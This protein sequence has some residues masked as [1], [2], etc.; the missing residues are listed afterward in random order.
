VGAVISPLLANVYLHRLDQEMQRAGFR[1]VR[2]ADDFIVTANRRWKVRLADQLVRSVLD[3]VGLSLNEDKTGVRNLNRDEID[4]LG[5]SFYAGRFLRPRERA[6]AAFKDRIRHLTRRKRGLSLQAII[7]SL[8]P[9]IR[10]WGIYFVE[11]HVAKLFEDLDQWIRMR[12]R[13]YVLGR[14]SMRTHI[15]RWMTTAT[16]HDKLGL[17]SLVALR[18]NYLSPGSG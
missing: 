2:Y 9:V 12:V 1:F 14:P 10:G 4:F 8:N 11:G 13:S 16:L 18:R 3:D 7:T 5:F 15:N 6:L 17:V